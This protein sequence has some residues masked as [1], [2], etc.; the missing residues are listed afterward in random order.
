MRAWIETVGRR[1]LGF[2]FQVGEVT[3][4]CVEISKWLFRPP[5]R[6]RLLLQQF[7]SIGYESIF[8]VCIT[9]LFTGM[10]SAIQIYYGFKIISADPLVGPT[11]AA[12][13]ARE[14]APVFTSI[15]VI[16]RSGAQMAALIGSMRVSEQID[17]LDVMAVN[18][19]QYLVVPRV[20]AS[21]FA[22]PMLTSLFEFVGNFGSYV[23]GVYFLKIDPVIYFA[24]LSDF[25]EVRDVIQGL[26]KAAAFGLLLSVIATFK[27]YHAIGG[28]EGV[29]RATTQAVVNTIVLV[30]ISDYFLTLVIR[31]FLYRTL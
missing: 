31:L 10:V 19:I 28:A 1:F 25:V 17:A 5:Y 15:V 6:F 26:I 21:F 20:V 29:G 27:G 9:A 4:F 22:L 7:I 11:V 23:T 30:L 2:V 24:H 8:I 14:L 13:L 18:S 3:L 12:G 16:G